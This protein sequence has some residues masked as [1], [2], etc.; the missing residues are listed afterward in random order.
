MMKK[1]VLSFLGAL[2][3]RDDTERVLAAIADPKKTVMV[4]VAP[5]VRTSWGEEFG[6]APEASTI[7][8]LAA[9]LHAI[10]ADYAAL[11]RA[12]LSL[13]ARLGLLTQNTP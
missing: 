3:E 2:C 11:E 6:L 10:G 13:A 1:S 7:E 5:A 8:R 4:Q 9:V 12:Y